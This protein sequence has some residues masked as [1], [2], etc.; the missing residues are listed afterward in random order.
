MILIG[1][2]INVMSTKIG[3]AMKNKDAK[4]IRELALAQQKA[5]MDYMDINIGPS[6]RRGPDVMDWIV[7]TIQEVVDLPLFLDTT[8]VEAIE[9]GLKVHKGEAVIN[10]IMCRPE[11]TEALFPLAKKYDAAFVGLLWGVEGMPRDAAER[12]ANAAE[13]MAAAAEQGIEDAKMWL[14]PIVAPVSSQQ[15]Q[16]QA[17]L[18]FMEMFKEMAPGCKSTCG[19][20]NVSNGSPNELRPILNQT[21]LMM[22]MKYGLDSA[23]VSAFDTDLVAIARGEREDLVNLVHRVMEGEEVDPGTLTQEEVDT[24]KTTKVLLGHSLYSDSWLKL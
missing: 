15:D 7:K 11:R 20:S 19:L 18:E 4:P 5:G 8:N 21:Y 3:A 9:A 16:V 1:E 2:N 17:L 14:D 12:G 13:L 23:I 10:S 6:K 24:V 22:L